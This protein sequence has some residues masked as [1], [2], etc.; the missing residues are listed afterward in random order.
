[1]RLFKGFKVFRGFRGFKVFRDFKVGWEVV[2]G[3]PG[4]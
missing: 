1:M 2:G 3:R 4:G